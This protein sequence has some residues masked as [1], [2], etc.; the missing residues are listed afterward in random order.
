[1]SPRVLITDSV[2]GGFEPERAV[3]DPLGV[4]LIIASDQSAEALIAQSADID[5]MLVCFA[6]IPASVIEAA[7]AGG[8]KIIARY[9]IGYDNIDIEAA[10]RAGIVVTNV[11]DYCFD[12][13][14]DHTMALLLGSVRAVFA[15]ARGVAQGGWEIDH[16][17][18][19]RVADRRLTILGLGGIGRRVAQRAQAFGIEVVGY[20][21]FVKA[22]EVP[23]VTVV[24]SL[25]E[26]L[27]AAD[28][29]SLHVPMTAE[30]SKLIRA[31]TIAMM[32]ASPILINTSRGG[33]VDLDD[34]VAALGDG[35]LSG[36]ALDVT[37]P[38]PLPADH[39]LRTHPHAVV[40]PHMAFHS[41]EA[42]E[43]LQRRAAQEIARSLRGEP[44]DRPVN[45]QAAR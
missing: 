29:V 42:T 36:V 11:P 15:A 34:V 9:G 25:E 3:L 33:L 40:T 6:S 20:D 5:G 31:E 45:P 10:T 12:E 18:V 17:A 21:P 7:A 35:T 24:D 39:P 4:E 30:N 26:A 13:V 32:K 14:A 23:G 28:I 22:G 1:M 38:E 27:E 43:E 44:A 16:A 41:V 37:D 2:F 8:A 19:R